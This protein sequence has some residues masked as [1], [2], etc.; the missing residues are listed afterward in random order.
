MVALLAQ[1][2][3]VNYDRTATS[4]VKITE[5]I[6]SLGYQSSVLEDNAEGHSTVELKVS[7]DPEPVGPVNVQFRDRRD[8]SV[9]TSEKKVCLTCN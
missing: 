3:E 4:A 5:H 6:S 7:G 1:K 8:K 2:A 9:R